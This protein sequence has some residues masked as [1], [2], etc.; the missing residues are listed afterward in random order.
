MSPFTLLSLLS[1]KEAK[2]FSFFVRDSLK[3]LP[4]KYSLRPCLLKSCSGFPLELFC[5]SKRTQVRPLLLWSCC[6]CW[7]KFEG[8]A[9]YFLTSIVHAIG[10]KD[11]SRIS[12][13]DED[14]AKL[15]RRPNRVLMNLRNEEWILQDLDMEENC[16]EMVSL[17]SGFK[18][19]VQRG[20]GKSTKRWDEIVRKE[21]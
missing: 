13:N 12:C 3:N 9:S 5:F 4:R 7:N 2:S 14:G 6:R 19:K 16:W 17:L 18:I 11:S 20:D 10:Q 21:K 8:V 15:G 1:I